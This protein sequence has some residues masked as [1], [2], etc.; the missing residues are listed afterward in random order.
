MI[1]KCLGEHGGQSSHEK[2]TE[3]VQQVRHTVGLQ[4]IL[5]PT[6]LSPGG[7]KAVDYAVALAEHFN[8][9]LTLLHV[10]AVPGLSSYPPEVIDYRFA[11]E[12]RAALDSFCLT[13]LRQFEKLDR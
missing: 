3:P 12:A 7:H 1:Q 4:R 8:A 2:R 11:E 5:V 6:D 9:Q 10:Y 13:H